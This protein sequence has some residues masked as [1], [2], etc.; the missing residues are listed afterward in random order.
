MPG[1]R[2]CGNLI[3]P[4]R[5]QL[6]M[7]RE[8]G[9]GSPVAAIGSNLA[10]FLGNRLSMSFGNLSCHRYRMFDPVK[11]TLDQSGAA[12]AAT[13]N[14]TRQIATP[15]RPGGGGD[16]CILPGGPNS[17]GRSPGGSGPG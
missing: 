10:S 15:C 8:A 13:F 11:V 16:R 17:R 14:I 12:T 4:A 5:S 2:V 7:T 1:T 9:F 6:D 3:S